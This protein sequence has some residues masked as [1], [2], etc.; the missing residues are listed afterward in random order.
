MITCLVNWGY[1]MEQQILK[2]VLIEFSRT[3]GKLDAGAFRTTR[4]WAS[5]TNKARKDAAFGGCIQREPAHDPPV[6]QR[7]ALCH[8]L[9]F[10]KEF[11]FAPLRLVLGP[12][13]IRNKN[14]QGKGFILLASD[15]ERRVQATRQTS[16]HPPLHVRHSVR[17]PSAGVRYWGVLRILA[18]SITMLGYATS[19]RYSKMDEQERLMVHMIAARP[20][21]A[22]ARK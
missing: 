5:T 11:V 16:H 15:S 2:D 14:G 19:R 9:S 17:V 18:M 21:R 6:N 13:Q 3:L 10:E 22:R 1:E 12:H 7:T 8:Q 20:R 4:F